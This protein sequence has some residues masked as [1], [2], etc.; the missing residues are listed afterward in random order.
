MAGMYCV[1]SKTT[2]RVLTQSAL[3]ESEARGRALTDNLPAGMV[4]QIATGPDGNERRFL[5]DP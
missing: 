1:V 3:A 5:H 4:Y 2:G